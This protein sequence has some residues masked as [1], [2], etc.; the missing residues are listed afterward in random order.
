M[1]IMTVNSFGSLRDNL[2]NPISGNS[3][4]F[5]LAVNR[6]EVTPPVKSKFTKLARVLTLTGAALAASHTLAESLINPVEVAKLTDV[7][8]GPLENPPF[9]LGSFVNGSL[10]APWTNERAV[11]N[12]HKLAGSLDSLNTW[13]GLGY[14]VSHQW[15]CADVNGAAVGINLLTNGTDTHA[16]YISMP[17]A[18]NGLTSANQNS[19]AWAGLGQV[20]PSDRKI[21]DLMAAGIVPNESVPYIF[22]AVNNGLSFQQK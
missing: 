1:A 22:D 4:Q 9:Q 17:G 5:G 6:T 3:S 16:V 10:Y 20:V 18:A 12:A 8:V 19:G 7:C 14:I 11:P 2:G 15:G 21:H 13:A